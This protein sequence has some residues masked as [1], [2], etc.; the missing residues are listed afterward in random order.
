MTNTLIHIFDRYN[1]QHH[2]KMDKMDKMKF[3]TILAVLLTYFSV[4]AATLA[5]PSI[6]KCSYYGDLYDVVNDVDSNGEYIS[7]DNGIHKAYNTGLKSDDLSSIFSSGNTRAMVKYVD[8]GMTNIKLFVRPK[9]EWIEKIGV[10]QC[11]NP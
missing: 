2:E 7:F 11:K 3:K 9:S 8:N 6:Y 1:L 10:Y 5:S 4:N